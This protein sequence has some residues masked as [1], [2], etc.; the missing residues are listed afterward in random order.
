M[1]IRLVAVVFL[2]WVIVGEK[3]LVIKTFVREEERM[4]YEKG[5]VKE[6]FK[7]NRKE[8]GSCHPI[9]RFIIGSNTSLFQFFIKGVNYPEG[10][11]ITVNKNTNM[12]VAKSHIDYK[13]H[14]DEMK[15]TL[16]FDCTQPDVTNE[17]FW[18]YV[19]IQVKDGPMVVQ[20]EVLKICNDQYRKAFDWSAI[21]IFILVILTVM[22]ASRVGITP[23][24]REEETQDILDELRFEVKPKHVIFFVILASLMLIL[25]FLFIK[26]VAK[27]L[28]VYFC[29]FGTILL[30][31]Y[32]HKLLKYCLESRKELWKSMS[33]SILGN[34]ITISEA[35]G[36]AAAACLMISWAITKY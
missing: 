33:R 10:F 3:E 9:S 11:E 8:P 7:P 15:G 4:I 35:I 21:L 5:E 22:L 1:W 20:F 34:Q 28:T 14:E 27:V 24:K 19:I 18:T 13:E 32:V 16:T 29:I 31:Y 26:Y 36:F 2:I 30:G 17:E 23:P 25:G 12:K 6:Q